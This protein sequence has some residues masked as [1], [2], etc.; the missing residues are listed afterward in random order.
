MALIKL[1]RDEAD[2][3]Y[4]PRVCMR[5]GEPADRDVPQTF[6]WMP[7]WV[8]FFILLGLA[9]WLIVALLTRKSMRVT[10]PM[11]DLH[12]GH[13]RVRKLF[14][15]LGLAFFVALFVGLVALGDRLPRDM[16]TPVI[17]SGLLAALIWL[18]AGLVFMN[19]AIR[20]AEIAADRIDLSNVLGKF[21]Q[22][23][24]DVLRAE[25]EERRWRVPVARQ[26]RR[27]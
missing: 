22:A 1:Y 25:R 16:H 26:P 20:A 10:A 2:G 21:A 27:D 5:C 12:R 11:C 24:R 19:G 4:F 15:G 8:H 7:S 13:W 3:E 17:V 23:W 6:A 18:I 14:I 9:P